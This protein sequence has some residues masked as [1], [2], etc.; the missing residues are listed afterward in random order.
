MQIFIKSNKNKNWHALLSALLLLKKRKG[1]TSFLELENFIRC[2][3][4]LKFSRLYVYTLL[5]EKKKK[6]KNLEKGKM[7]I[8]KVNK[9]DNSRKFIFF[10]FVFLAAD[11]AISFLV[12]R[13]A[14][15][16]N[17]DTKKGV[18]FP[19]T[20]SRRPSSPPL[21]SSVALLPL[22]RVPHAPLFK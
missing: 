1:K 15:P 17:I 3:E 20:D 10:F 13:V 2:L 14:P 6:L 18:A 21:S 9:R 16:G 12:G 4:G 11:P 22:D 19:V 5:F 8:N 7:T